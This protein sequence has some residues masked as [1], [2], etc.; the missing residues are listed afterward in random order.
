MVKLWNS[1]R[2]PD[3]R[4]IETQ[5]D[6]LRRMSGEVLARYQ[7]ELKAEISDPE[8]LAL[9]YGQAF[10]SKDSLR[11]AET[12]AKMATD[13]LRVP[14]AAVSVIREH[15][16]EFIAQA[17]RM[18]DPVAPTSPL[19]DSFCQHIIATGR[20][21]VVDDADEHPLVCNSTYTRDGVITSYLGVPVANRDSVVI[22]VL[23]VWDSEKRTWSLA[24]VGMLTQLSM[25]LTRSLPA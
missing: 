21:M 17:S 11:Q 2:L 7:R 5:Q 22:G 16:Q 15:E 24:D 19:S 20:E 9:V 25:V 23:C 3:Q 1:R 6:K 14:H 4:E 18:A 13:M 8:R 12:V 10:A